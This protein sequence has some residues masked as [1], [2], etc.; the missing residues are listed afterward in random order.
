M[1]LIRCSYRNANL[2]KLKPLWSKVYPPPDRRPLSG[3]RGASLRTLSTPPGALRLAEM[4]ANVL[5]LVSELRW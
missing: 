1:M 3:T 5:Q 2:S 4:A